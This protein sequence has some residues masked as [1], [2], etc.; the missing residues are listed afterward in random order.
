[1]LKTIVAK[2]LGTQGASL[3]PGAVDM[4]KLPTTAFE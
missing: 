4:D 2:W 3:L 1:V